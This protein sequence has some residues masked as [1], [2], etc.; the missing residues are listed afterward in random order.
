[1][2]VF[3][4][5]LARILA[6]PA[7]IDWLIARA[8]RTPYFHITS[9]DGRDIYMER[10][11]LFNP[12]PPKSDGAKRRWGNWLPSVRLHRILRADQDRHLHD[13][14]WNARTFIL[15][16]WYRELRQVKV[17]TSAGMYTTTV[18][19]LREPGHT[20]A[21]RFGEYHRI[22]Q[23]SPGGVWTLFITWRHRG[24]WGFL[25]DGKKVPWREYL[26]ANEKAEGGAV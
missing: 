8:M 5:L 16:G 25:V 24:T 4:N 14:P 3:P 10:Y 17:K 21:L 15:R 23:V 12:Y 1:M 9:A 7:V 6:Q 13:H 18:R 11:W 22:T 26:A 20:G 19:R 2:S